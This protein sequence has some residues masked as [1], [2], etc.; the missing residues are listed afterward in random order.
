MAEFFP[1]TGRKRY[2]PNSSWMRHDHARRPSGDAAIGSFDRCVE[3]GAWDQP[4]D[5]REVEE[6]GERRR[7]EDR[8]EGATF[9]GS[10]PGR[11]GGDRG[12]PPLYASPAG[13]LSVRL[14]AD[15]PASDAIRFASSPS[16]S[17]VSRLPD[18]T[19]DKPSKRRFKAYAIG[20]VHLDVA[21]VRTAEG[22]L[23]L[24]VAIDRM[25][26]FAF[27][28][29][30][31]KAGKMAAAQFLCDLIAAPPYRLHTVLTD[32]GVQFT[33]RACDVYAF[34]HIF[35]RDCRENGIE[36]RLTKLKH[37]WTNGQV[38]RM[39]RTIKEAT[40][41]RFHYDT[42]DQLR[43]HLQ[44]FVDA[45]N[46]ARRLKTLRGLTPYEHIGK[47]WTDEPDRFIRNPIQQIQGPNS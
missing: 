4:E 35:D 40:V 3:P 27:T 23:Y 46:F 29:L 42:H 11:R 20:Y 24:F 6:P 12:F 5:G 32:N 21:E 18:V 44:A 37:P 22:K 34:E 26:K 45:Y 14:A 2:G 43:C 36:H 38:E 31:E 13:R 7:P 28:R 9:N 39:N 1:E 25:S 33:N 17:R 8:P 16:A 47:A 15:D 41:K 30:V 10:Q 19:G